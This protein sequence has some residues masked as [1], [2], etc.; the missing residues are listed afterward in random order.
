MKNNLQLF[1]EAERSN[2]AQ[3]QRRIC[4][5]LLRREPDHLPALELKSKSLWRSG[6]FREA[7]ET[8][9][10][11]IALNPQELGYYFLRGD[12]LQHLARYGEAVREFEKCR[13]SKDAQLSSEAEIRIKAL[14]AFQENII[15][16]LINCN[17]HFRDE[18]RERPTEALQAH[19]FAFSEK[20]PDETAIEK[21]VKPSLWARPS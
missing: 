9:S 2:D 16:E 12:C 11:A 15:A 17:P 21:N 5:T 4:N 3:T 13:D 6:H 19:G 1:R 18:Y 20:K 7:L 8:I 14:E 10:K